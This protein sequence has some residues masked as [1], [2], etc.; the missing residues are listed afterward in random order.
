MKSIKQFSIEK[1]NDFKTFVFIGIEDEGL[2]TVSECRNMSSLKELT[3]K[4][5]EAREV[6]N[7]HQDLPTTDQAFMH[8][9]EHLNES[10]CRFLLEQYQNTM[11]TIDNFLTRERNAIYGNLSK[12]RY[13]KMHEEMM[14]IKDIYYILDDVKRLKFPLYLKR[15]KL[16]TIK[17]LTGSDSYEKIVLPD[18]IPIKFTK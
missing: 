2:F 17:D 16:K 4:I 18:I 10:Q 14:L 8:F 12:I 5:K 13:I 15:I 6:V 3:C 9:E 11:Y 1:I 7:L